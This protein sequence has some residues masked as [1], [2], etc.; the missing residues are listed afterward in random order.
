MN[1]FPTSVIF[2]SVA[3]QNKLVDLHEQCFWKS[4]NPIPADNDL[5]RFVKQIAKLVVPVKGGARLEEG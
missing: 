1:L 5:L 3:Q 4:Q 2:Y